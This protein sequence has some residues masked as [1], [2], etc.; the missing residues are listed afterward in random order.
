MSKKIEN[1][2]VNLH[3]EELKS[4]L[5]HIINNNRFL[6]S[7][8]KLPVTVNVEGNAGLGKTSAIAQ[9]ANELGIN[10][11]RV[12]LAM[13]EELGDLVGFPVRQFELCKQET[14]NILV[15]KTITGEDGK[16]KIVN[17]AI[18]QTVTIEG[19]CMWVDEH[20][21]DEYLKHGYTFTG[22]KQMTYCPPEWIVGLGDKGGILLLDDYSR[23]D[24]RFIQ[25]CMTL[26]ETQKYISW[27]L[28]QDWHIILTTNPDDGEY[29]VTPMDIAQKT[30]F[31]SV[32]LKFDVQS[33]AR[34][35][36][37]QGVDG[38]CINFLLM[39]PEL[40]TPETNPR[41]ITTFFNAIS[42]IPSFID[43]LPLIQMIGE[44]SVGTEFSTLFTAFINHKLDRLIT[45]K[46]LLLH[47]NEAHVMGEL[48]GCIG[49][50]ASYRA[51]I[52]STLVTRLINFAV[53]YAEEHTVPQKT[54][55]R[56][57]KISTSETL[58]Y[59]LKYHLVKKILNGNKQKFQGIM[60]NKDVVVMAM[61]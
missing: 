53:K 21:V 58:T 31:I 54:I 9:L 29:L 40:V 15:P 5:T 2:L 32:N 4:F 55:D 22:E 3:I 52:A 6:Q 27:S 11:I 43:D 59:D 1:K 33:W 48:A 56:L 61:K 47:D 46:D 12:N 24:S 7:Q 50:G 41:S 38:R 42:S 14:K 13:I 19:S 8:G 17:V 30:R 35:A 34:W 37:S 18:P 57:I 49:T 16:S 28:P 45:P 20:A 51:D 39:H 26:I 44:G 10:F 36:E 25:A 23:A 60:M